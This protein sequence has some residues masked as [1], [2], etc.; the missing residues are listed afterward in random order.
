M[1]FWSSVEA[2]EDKKVFVSYLYNGDSKDID[3]SFKVV[4]KDPML[5][6]RFKFFAIN[7]PGDHLII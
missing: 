2:R 5:A 1:Y 6:D 3:P 4:T 7:K